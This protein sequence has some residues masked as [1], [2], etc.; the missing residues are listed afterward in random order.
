MKKFVVTLL[1]GAFLFTSLAATIGCT[2]EKKPEK[3]KDKK[4]EKDKGDKKDK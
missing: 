1:M 4:A 3:D 2:E